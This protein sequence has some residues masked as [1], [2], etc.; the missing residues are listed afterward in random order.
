MISVNLDWL[1]HNR[2]KGSSV[3]CN[4]KL[5]TREQESNPANPS[6]SPPGSVTF[7]HRVLL[8]FAREPPKSGP[9]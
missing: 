2:N 6:R 5:Q 7:L 9:A 1:L 8:D 4:K 3:C